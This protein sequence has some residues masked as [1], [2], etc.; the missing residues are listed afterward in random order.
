MKLFSFL[1]NRKSLLLMA[2]AVLLSQFSMAQDA[3]STAVPVAAAPAE[4]T[5]SLMQIFLILI[6]AVLGIVI[7]G[8]GQVI[9]LLSKQL[10][11]KQKNKNTRDCI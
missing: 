10:I 3:A 6:V 1:K 9:V 4:A 7:W 11:E 5:Q 8:M 2:T